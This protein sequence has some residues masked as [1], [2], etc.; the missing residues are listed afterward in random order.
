MPLPLFVLLAAL[1]GAPAA[2]ESPAKPPRVTLRGAD[3]LDPDWAR[4]WAYVDD[5]TLLIDAG[6]RKYRITLDFPSF[7]LAMAIDLGF[8]GDVIS[9]RLCGYGSEYLLVRGKRQ[10]IDRIELIDDATYRAAT[11]R[12]PKAKAPP[13]EPGG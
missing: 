6:R 9:D 8:R 2:S 1:S 13:S 12:K 5:R 3:C 7:D 10:Y 4:S 11:A